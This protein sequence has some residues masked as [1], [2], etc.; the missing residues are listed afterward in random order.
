MGS[1]DKEH[2]AWNLEHGLQPGEHLPLV[3]P[4]CAKPHIETLTSDPSQPDYLH[5]VHQCTY[6]G[7][8]FDLYVR[9]RS[10]VAAPA[11]VDVQAL[12]GGSDE[13]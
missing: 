4:R 7:V 12:D 3:C 11:R 9:T 6:C 13:E 10:S 1:R 5:H 8:R 2:E